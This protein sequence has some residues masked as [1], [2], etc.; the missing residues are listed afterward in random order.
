MSAVANLEPAGCYDEL[1]DLLDDTRVARGLSFEHLEE[2]G[3]LASNHAQKALG[4][5]RAKPLTPMLIDTLLSVLGIRL[6][7]VDDPEAIASMEGRWEQRNESNVRRNQRVSQRI[8]NRAR[9]VILQEVVDALAGA[10]VRAFCCN[11]KV[12]VAEAVPQID[13]PPTPKVETAKPRSQSVSRAHLHVVQPRV[14]RRPVGRCTVGQYCPVLE[15]NEKP[16]IHTLRPPASNCLV[17]KISFRG[18]G[19]V[20]PRV[21]L[22]NVVP[23]FR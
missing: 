1:V 23:N 15:R 11:K 17:M 19:C 6:A 12:S 16:G 4:P 2:L 13:S 14:K 22:K 21:E 3:G 10:R 8:L 9:P 5:A 20:G 7:I 18:P